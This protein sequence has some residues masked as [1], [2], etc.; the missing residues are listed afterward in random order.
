[1]SNGDCIFTR[2]KVS[3]KSNTARNRLLALGFYPSW[4]CE[5]DRDNEFSKQCNVLYKEIWHSS[6]GNVIEI[7]YE[8]NKRNTLDLLL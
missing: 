3:K 5:T 6:N 7:S 2:W 8:R 4:G 1:M